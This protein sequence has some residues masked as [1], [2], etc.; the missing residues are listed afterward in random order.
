VGL[1]DYDPTSPR[2]PRHPQL[3][4]RLPLDRVP[5]GR[6]LLDR[7]LVDRVLPGRF[8]ACCLIASYWHSVL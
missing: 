7:T 2:P 4:D 8:T 3:L 5:L 1:V 6:T